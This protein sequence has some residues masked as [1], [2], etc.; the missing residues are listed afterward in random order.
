MEYISVHGS[1]RNTPS[2]TEVLAEHKLKSGQEYLASRKEYI[3]Q[4]KTR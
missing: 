3:E 2:D 4:C 1:I